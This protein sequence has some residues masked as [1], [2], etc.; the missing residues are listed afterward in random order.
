[1]ES[2]A[3][4]VPAWHCSLRQLH[5]HSAEFLTPQGFDYM[6][7][8]NRQCTFQADPSLPVNVASMPFAQIAKSISIRS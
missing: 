3:A 4:L 5:W 2:L 6:T 7:R 8:K 1:M